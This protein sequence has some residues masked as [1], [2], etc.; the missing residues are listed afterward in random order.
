MVSDV[1]GFLFYLF[2]LIIKK[3]LCITH[4]IGASYATSVNESNDN[5][6]PGS[7]VRKTK[8]CDKHENTIP[9]DSDASFE[10]SQ[11]DWTFNFNKD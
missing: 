6:R 2:H 1:L 11:S 10:L 7:S 9:T 4:L 5:N 8:I 3:L